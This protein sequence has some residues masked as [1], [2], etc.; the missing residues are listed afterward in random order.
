MFYYIKLFLYVLTN[1]RHEI[2]FILHLDIKLSC[3]WYYL[4][5][6][7]IEVL[8]IL[9]VFDKY[10]ADQKHTECIF[11]FLTFTYLYDSI[12][13]C[14]S[15]KKTLFNPTIFFTAYNPPPPYLQKSVQK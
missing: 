3:T 1:L 6:K 9:N 13:T 12:S 14:Y 7:F 8:R 4:T 11:Y 2:I 5:S 15:K 10:T